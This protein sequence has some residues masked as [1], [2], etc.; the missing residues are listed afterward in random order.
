MGEVNNYWINFGRDGLDLRLPKKPTMKVGKVNVQMEDTEYYTKEEVD[1]IIKDTADNT[2][3]FKEL[4][5][6]SQN[7]NETSENTYTLFRGDCWTINNNFESSAAITSETTTD[8]RVNG[9]F[10]TKSDMIGLYWNSKDLITHPYISYG[11]HSDYR[12]VTLEFDYSMTGCRDFN[13]NSSSITLAANTGEIYYLQL[14]RFINNGHVTLDFSGLTLLP[15]NQYIDR[16]GNAVTVTTET[17]VD[18]SNLKFIMFVLIPT[19]YEENP[20]GYEI[21]S[22][23]DFNCEITNISVTNGYI[24][25]EHTFL[26][27]HKYRLCEGY[28]DFY[29]MNPKRVCKEMRKLGYTSWLDLYIGASH[30]YEKSGTPGEIIDVSNFNHTRTEKMVLNKNVPLNKSFRAWLDCYSRELKANDCENLVI[31]VSMENLQCPSSWRQKDCNGNDAIT[32]WIPSTFFYTPC[33]SEVAPYMQSVSEACLD[34]VVANN[35]QP[36]LQMGEAWWWWNEND[37][38]NQPPCFYDAATKAAYLQEFGVNMPE[39]TTAWDKIYDKSLMY[40]LNKKLCGYSDKLREVVKSDKYTNGL[41]MALFF[42]PSVL[43]KDRVP[44]MMKEVNYIKEAY[45]PEKLDVLQLEDYDWVT[46][47]SPE[48]KE[49]DRSHHPQVYTIGQS[50]GFPEDRLHYFG[51]FVQYPKDAVEYWREIIKAMDTAIQKGFKETFVWAGSQIRRDNKIIGYDN[52][53]LVLQLKD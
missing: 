1:E 41:Y 49:R 5:E 7:Y 17:P 26:E 15:G 10:R 37:H 19:V 53:E 27:P 52:Y 34:I 18:V 38:P 47:L 31:S 46:G 21:I 33:N 40:W 44:P 24:C 25:N 2:A 20:L 30:F 11:E 28:D 29:N 6:V 14:N 50:L 36:I 12:G 13:H 4:L 8:F 23:V 48:T 43:D 16:N 39:H 35:M 51:G 22:N 42:P 45:S 9:T 3:T 32:G